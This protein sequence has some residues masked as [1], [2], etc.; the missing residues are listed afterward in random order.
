MKVAVFV[1][2][3]VRD[4]RVLTWL[5]LQIIKRGHTV[6]LGETASLRHGLDVIEPYVWVSGGLAGS[7]RKTELVRRLKESGGALVLVESEGSLFSDQAF[8][9]HGIHE[10]MSKYTDKHCT[11]GT[12]QADLLC[13]GLGNYE[14]KIVVSENP[15][16]DSL[17]SDLRGVYRNT[18]DEY[19]EQY[20]EYV[21]INANFGIANTDKASLVDPDA[22]L[23]SYQSQLISKYT[24]AARR[25]VSDLD[26]SVVLRPH[27]RED[28]STY[29]TEF[30]D[31]ENVYARREGG[32]RPWIMGCES[33]RSQ[34]LD[35]RHQE[36]T[37]RYARIQLSPGHK[38][39]LRRRTPNSRECRERGL[40][41]AS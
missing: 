30:A 39:G 23:E 37:P 19:I 4:F 7:E 14:D 5:A 15:R 20:G 21:L 13:E 38:R 41:R 22:D 24:E 12:R 31:D 25:L 36:C 9:K 33:C 11:W 18:A 1:E 34:K 26:C 28:L 6:V 27:S 35:H 10:E 2:N 17:S 3:K 40:P 8:R 16:F 29:E 32:V